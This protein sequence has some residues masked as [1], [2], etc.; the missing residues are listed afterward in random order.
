[1]RLSVVRRSGQND[2]RSLYAAIERDGKTYLVRER[3][4]TR[5]GR[6]FCATTPCA[7]ASR[8]LS[9]RTCSPGRG[10]SAGRTA[11]R[12]PVRTGSCARTRAAAA[13]ALR[14]PRPR[15]GCAPARRVSGGRGRPGR[16]GAAW[17]APVRRAPG[18]RWSESRGDLPLRVR[19]R[20]LQEDRLQARALPSRPPEPLGRARVAR[21]DDRGALS[22]KP[23]TRRT[24]RCGRR[25]RRTRRARP[26]GPRRPSTSGRYR[27]VG[28]ARG[29]EPREIGPRHVVEDV[30]PDA[31]RTGSGARIS[32]GAPERPWR[33]A[34]RKGSE[35]M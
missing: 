34:A 17:E 16:A 3:S 18:V 33:L 7:G 25:R 9:F 24:G 32:T 5:R 27:I 14:A 6:I 1:M 31:V 30:P 4:S 35:E 26:P 23:R 20:A 11:S 21:E 12:P 15:G 2:L 10:C 19:E 29:R 28:R 8:E 22:R 13:A